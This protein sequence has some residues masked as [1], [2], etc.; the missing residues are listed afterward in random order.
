MVKCVYSCLIFL[1]KIFGRKVNRAPQPS[2]QGA[3]DRNIDTLNI[4]SMNEKNQ[5]IS[6]KSE[7]QLEDNGCCQSNIVTGMLSDNKPEPVYKIEE[8]PSNISLSP[9]SKR[10]QSEDFSPIK[11]PSPTG[12]R[13]FHRIPAIFLHECNGKMPKIAAATPRIKLPR[14]YA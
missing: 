13:M 3:T 8:S 11:I 10:S 1:K 2:L 14:V 12:I 6:L 7:L 5:V 4:T 9:I